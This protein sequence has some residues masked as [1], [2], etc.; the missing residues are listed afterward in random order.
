MNQTNT[1][2]SETLI[3]AYHATNYHVYTEP[4][5]TLKVDQKSEQLLDL[6]HQKNCNSAAFITAH[7]PFSK[8]VSEVE[9]NQRNE[10]LLKVIQQ[11]ETI[12]GKGLSEDEQHGEDSFLVLGLGPKES[13][14]IGNQFEQNAIVW[15]GENAIPKLVL[16]R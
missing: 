11:Y 1:A 10:Q 13:I 16:I 7:N 5:F 14:E 12:N 3:T 8:T 2:I 4:S 15:V 6:F 9:N